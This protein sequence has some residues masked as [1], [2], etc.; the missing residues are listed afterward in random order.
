MVV[1][2]LGSTLEYNDPD[3]LI[4][5]DAAIGSD[6]V[7]VDKW[8]KFKAVVG[9]PDMNRDQM[10]LS[11]LNG[12]V[13][14]IHSVTDLPLDKVVRY[15]NRQYGLLSRQPTDYMGQRMWRYIAQAEVERA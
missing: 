7:V 13:I 1:E 11:K 2:Q 5:G 10:M 4:P 6:A 12:S 8:V 14:Q 15:E 9:M 3:V